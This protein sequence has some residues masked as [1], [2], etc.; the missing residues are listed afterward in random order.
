MPHE[1]PKRRAAM[2]FFCRGNATSNVKAVFV[3]P[4][5]VGTAYP[6]Q[7]AVHAEHRPALRNGVGAVMPPLYPA[8]FSTPGFTSVGWGIPSQYRDSTP[9][10]KAPQCVAT[11]VWGSVL[12][13]TRQRHTG[14][15]RRGLPAQVYRA[16][17]FFT[18]FPS[19]CSKQHSV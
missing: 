8:G 10:H 5:R 15:T 9:G 11:T 3:M 17:S 16:C 19:S 18:V 7:A 14:G 2:Q 1:K 6:H 12:P 13:H 4:H